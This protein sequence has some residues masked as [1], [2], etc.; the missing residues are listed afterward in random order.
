MPDNIQFIRLL[1]RCD[2]HHCI[3]KGKSVSSCAM[4]Q[5]AKVL[6]IFLPFVK[7]AYLLLRKI[8]LKAFKQKKIAVKRV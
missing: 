6:M 7:T 1:P 5:F 4:F 2:R 8:K 3:E